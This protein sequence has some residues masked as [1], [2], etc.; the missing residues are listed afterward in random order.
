MKPTNL[1]RKFNWWWLP[2]VVGVLIVL[3]T[4]VSYLM[5]VNLALL[6]ILVPAIACTGFSGYKLLGDGVGSSK[7]FAGISELGPVM[8]GVNTFC[9]YGKIVNGEHL[10]E[11]VQFEDVAMEKVLGDRWFFEDLNKWLYVMFNDLADEDKWKAFE[12]PDAEYTDPARLSVQLNMGRIN[13]LFQLEP[14]LFDQLKPWL[15]VA[16]ITVVGFLIFLSGSE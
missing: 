5:S 13:E 16:V 4:A 14:S 12:L 2:T 3:A 1:K 10:A 8:G 11:K 9:I 15:M 7:G 6:L